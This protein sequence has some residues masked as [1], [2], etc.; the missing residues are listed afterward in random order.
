[1]LTPR[2]TMPRLLV[3]GFVLAAGFLAGCDR[4]TGSAAPG[5]AEATL[6]RV[7][8]TKTIR[9]GYVVYPPAV[10]KPAGATRP[11]GLFVD[12]LDRAAKLMDVNVEYVEEASFGTMIDAL[13]SGRYDVLCG[14][15]YANGSRARAVDFSVPIYYSGMNAWAR[16][17]DHRFDTD[18][19]LINDPGVRISVI[20][21]EIT[22]NVAK[23]RF[24]KARIVSL[25]ESSNSN[26]SLMNVATKKADVV[27]GEPFLVGQFN[28]KNNGVL[29]NVSRTPLRVFPVVM[30]FRKTDGEFRRSLDSAFTELQNNG[31][32]EVLLKQHFKDP[33]TYYLVAPPYQT[34]EAGSGRGG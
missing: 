6:P 27:F 15:I 28:E 17:D 14:P 18:I 22:E 4:K 34:H 8:R 30:L 19:Q 29:R 7:L 5:A 2:H 25:P 21:G 13:N 10:A 9:A 3:V 20:D 23:L 26:D 11:T 33:S 31:E 24:P 12:V 16:N 32:V 1:M